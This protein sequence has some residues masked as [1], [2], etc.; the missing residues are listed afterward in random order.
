MCVSDP[1]FLW[2]HRVYTHTREIKNMY[3]M[4]GSGRLLIYSKKKNTKKQE[5]P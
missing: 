5:N 4:L 3:G 1:L 2:L